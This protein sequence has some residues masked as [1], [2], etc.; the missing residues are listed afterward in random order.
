[1]ITEDFDQEE[2]MFAM[3]GQTGKVVG[4]PPVSK[5]KA[6][7]WFGAITAASFVVMKIISVAMGGSFL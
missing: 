7:A 6:A 2:Y 1:M 3:N 5:G 4:K